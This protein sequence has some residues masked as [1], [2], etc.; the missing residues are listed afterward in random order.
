MKFKYIAL[1]P[2]N[3]RVVG[4]LEAE[5]ELL[6]QGQLHRLHLAIVS[7]E[8]ISNEA[9]E[10]WQKNQEGEKQKKG[11]KTFRF[12][13]VDANQQT[14]DGTIDAVSGENAYDRLIKDYHFEVQT[15]HPVLA[16]EAEQKQFEAQLATWKAKVH[17]AVSEP[18]RL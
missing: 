14:V 1:T 8:P 7:I 15:L 13:A 2:Q 12:V 11:I 16:N 9:Y 10:A 18:D 4:A 3:E 5:S 6:A 17:R